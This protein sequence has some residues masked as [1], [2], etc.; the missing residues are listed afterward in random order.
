MH[1]I[2]CVLLAD[3]MYGRA[4]FAAIIG[5]GGHLD[6][7][8]QHTHELWDTNHN[9]ICGHPC[10]VQLHQL[11]VNADHL[12]R[13]EGVIDHFNQLLH[14]VIRGRS[15]GA[16]NGH[17]HHFAQCEFINAFVVAAI[18]CPDVGIGDVAAYQLGDCLDRTFFCAGGQMIDDVQSVGFL[19]C[20]HLCSDGGEDRF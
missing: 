14:Y 2:V 18:G 13:I 5:F 20:L 17:L 4:K 19:L 8:Q 12:A 6:V 1:M 15:V 11:H 3:G 16:V 10:H 7:G 9:A